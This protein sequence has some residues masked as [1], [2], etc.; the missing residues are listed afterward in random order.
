MNQSDP[1][2]G[3]LIRAPHTAHCSAL[4]VVVCS[5]QD[6]MEM[7]STFK[8]Q[9]FQLVHS[10]FNPSTTSDPLYVLDYQQQSYIPL[11]DGIYRS[12]QAGERKL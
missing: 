7:T 8:Q 9:K 11:T 10:G 4:T 3:T 1:I 12:I 2:M 5:P 6:V